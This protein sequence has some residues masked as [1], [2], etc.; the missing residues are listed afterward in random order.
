MD[1]TTKT[2]G[3]PAAPPTNPSSP[4]APTMQRPPLSWGAFRH[5]ISDAAMKLHDARVTAVLGSTVE[6]RHGGALWV[7]ASS[8]YGQGRL[9]RNADGSSDLHATRSSDGAT[10]LDQHRADVHLSDFD[11]LIDAITDPRSAPV[12]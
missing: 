8:S 7:S 10:L 11:A 5:L 12:R 4:V 9:V 2:D 6:Q 3:P 1:R